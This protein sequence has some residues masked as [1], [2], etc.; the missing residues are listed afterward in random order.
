ML[1]EEIDIGQVELLLAA[2]R[3]KEVI[4]I[5][6]KMLSELLKVK[7]TEINVE[8]DTNKLER[9][10]EKIN[11]APDF[12][13]IPNSIKTIGEVISK[14]IQEQKFPEPVKKWV[15]TINRDD[16][17]LYKTITSIAK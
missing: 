7:D 17:G 3:H 4:A 6:N 8:V 5:M 2:K 15:H 14:K 16:Q 1:M 13:S 11:T 10:L 9:I 12:S